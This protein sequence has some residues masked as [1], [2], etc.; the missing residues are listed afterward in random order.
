MSNYII[1]RD[2]LK[3]LISELGCRSTVHCVRPCLYSLCLPWSMV[4]L[5]GHL[6]KT[7]LW[8]ISTCIWDKEKIIYCVN[9]M[10]NFVRAGSLGIITADHYGSRLPNFLLP[11]VG[12]DTKQVQMICLFEKIFLCCYVHTWVNVVCKCII[13]YNPKP[14]S[15][16][17]YL[18]MYRDMGVVGIRFLFALKG[19]H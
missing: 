5:P 15:L 14:W 9:R 4:W 2:T 18:H 16:Q 12:V 19:H 7:W 8:C 1:W 11:E 3:A 10:L 13:L 17:L 6:V